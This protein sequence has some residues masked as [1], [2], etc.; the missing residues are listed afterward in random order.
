MQK[1]DFCGPDLK[2]GTSFSRIG[3]EDSRWYTGP[4]S[5]PVNVFRYSEIFT[6]WYTAYWEWSLANPVSFEAQTFFEFKQNAPNC[7]LKESNHLLFQRFFQ[8]QDPTL[9]LK[10]R[11]TLRQRA[12]LIRNLT[13]FLVVLLPGRPWLAEQLLLG[14]QIESSLVGKAVYLS[15]VSAGESSPQAILAQN[16]LLQYWLETAFREGFSEYFSTL[17]KNLPCLA[18]VNFYPGVFLNAETKKRTKRLAT[19]T[20]RLLYANQKFTLTGVKPWGSSWQEVVKTASPAALEITS[21][22]AAGLPTVSLVRRFEVLRHKKPKP[23]EAESFW[24]D[25]PTGFVGYHRRTKPNNFYTKLF[26]DGKFTPLGRTLL[27]ENQAFLQY[28]YQKATRRQAKAAKEEND[29]LK[30]TWARFLQITYTTL[31]SIITQSSA[32]DYNAQTT[33]KLEPLYT[34]T[35]ARHDEQRTQASLLLRLGKTFSTKNPLYMDADVSLPGVELELGQK[36]LTDFLNL[37]EADQAMRQTG[38]NRLRGF[39]ALEQLRLRQ[40]PFSRNLFECLNAVYAF[41]TLILH[42]YHVTCVELKALEKQPKIS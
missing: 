28:E 26:N 33:S 29:F 42:T 10:T 22:S 31:D 1:I 2:P 20:T 6:L 7:H 24:F 19:P 35:R 17:L 37:V 16:V 8:R 34:Y 41:L 21:K 38:L 18:R 15:E 12:Q 23:L 14:L 36:S 5:T 40:S 4:F 39:L 27:K 3:N 13:E 11:Q 32:F 9:C 25:L 30:V